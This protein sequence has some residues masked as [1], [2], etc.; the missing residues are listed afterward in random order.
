[1]YSPVQLITKSV[2]FPERPSTDSRVGE[3]FTH[4]FEYCGCADWIA[5]LVLGPMSGT[6][7]ET[8]ALRWHSSFIAH[9]EEFIQGIPMTA[10]QGQ[11][12]D[13]FLPREEA[14]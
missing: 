8:G 13:E 9:C 5:K 7:E 10:L 11:G 4:S 1:M 3:F 14:V 6:H 12:L 2:R